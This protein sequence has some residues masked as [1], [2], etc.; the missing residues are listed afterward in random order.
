MGA[1]ARSCKEGEGE[2]GHFANETV[3]LYYPLEKKPFFLCKGAIMRG[4]RDILISVLRGLALFGW[5]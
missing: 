1:N 5:L 2:G 4:V 3:A